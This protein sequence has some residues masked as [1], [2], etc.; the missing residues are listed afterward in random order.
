MMGYAVGPTI[1]PWVQSRMLIGRLNGTSRDGYADGCASSMRS[2]AAEVTGL[3]IST[4]T[5]SW[6]WFVSETS[7]TTFRGR[8]PECLVREPSAGHPLARFDEAGCGNG[9]MEP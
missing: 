7:R 5:M 9:V 6:V 2:A 3:R 1:L 4:C 8:T